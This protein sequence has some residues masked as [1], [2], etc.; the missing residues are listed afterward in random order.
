MAC[1]PGSVLPEGRD[2]H[3]SG[4]FLAK[5]LTRPTRTTTRKPAKCRPYLVLLPVGL[6]M[7][8]SLPNPRCALTAPF[9]PYLGPRAVG[10]LF[11]VAL[12]LGSP[13]PGVTRHR[14][15]VEPGLSS[16]GRNLQRPSGHL[17]QGPMSEGWAPA[18]SDWI[19]S[20]SRNIL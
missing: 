10:G 13:P 4:T 3:S 12:S 1:K 8:V 20:Q 7:P 15:S 2:G 16:R 11:S 17:T 19:K 18:S 5:R 6:A 9:H 14:V